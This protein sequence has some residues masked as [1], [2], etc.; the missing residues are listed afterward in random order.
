MLLGKM[1]APSLFAC[2][3]E[4]GIQKTPGLLLRR[5]SLQPCEG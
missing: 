1:A 4:E 3:R 2:P 5:H